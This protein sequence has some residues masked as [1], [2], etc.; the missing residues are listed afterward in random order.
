[1]ENEM[2][3]TKQ[4]MILELK[5]QIRLYQLKEKEMNIN[6]IEYVV[7]SEFELS[8]DD[9]HNQAMEAVKE[10]IRGKV[11]QKRFEVENFKEEGLTFNSV[12]A[13]GGLRELITILNEIDYLK[14]L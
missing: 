3:P 2:K 12:E 4:E 9:I 8:R 6:G 1:M 10:M 11:D 14:S 7:K 5:K 13:E